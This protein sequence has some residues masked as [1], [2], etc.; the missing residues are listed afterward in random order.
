MLGSL[1]RRP[2]GRLAIVAVLATSAGTAAAVG[3]DPDRPAPATAAIGAPCLARSASTVAAIDAFAARRI[4]EAELRGSETRADIGHITGSAALAGALAKSDNAAVRAAVHA[5]VYAP[6]WHIVRLRVLDNAGHVVS[7]IGGPYIIAPVTGKLRW[8][9]R[10]VGRF[11]MSVQD[12]VGYVKLV[13]RFIGI[14]IEL[15]RNGRPLMGTIHPVQRPVSEGSV[16]M[17]GG[18]EHI[19]EVMSARAFPTGVLRIALMVPAPEGSASRQSCAALAVNAWG[20]I[21]KH[22]ASRFN[23]LD[24]HFGELVGVLQAITGG[25]AYVTTG[26][27]LVAGSKAPRPLPTAGMVKFK[28]RSWTVF[29]WSPAPQATVYL[30]TRPG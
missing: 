17:M 16:L 30:L 6:G 28:G 1:S 29:S 13:S 3:V 24:A 8:H 9:G 27:R 20:S 10:T 15:Y 14:P 26:A 11:A 21:A 23:P 18:R 2:R 12:D 19:A 5:I 4:Y 22:I 25:P 7:D